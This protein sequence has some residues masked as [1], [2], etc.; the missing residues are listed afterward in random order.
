MSRTNDDAPTAKITVYGTP[1]YDTPAN[2]VPAATHWYWSAGDQWCAVC[3]EHESEW[4]ADCPDKPAIAERVISDVPR[5]GTLHF[6]L[7][8]HGPVIVA[9]ADTQIERGHGPVTCP[10]CDG[11]TFQEYGRTMYTQRVELERDEATGEILLG[12]YTGDS[13][14]VI[15]ADEAEG[16]QC[17]GCLTDIPVKG[18][19]ATAD[20]DG[21]RARGCAE[22]VA[23]TLAES[24]LAMHR[25]L[26]SENYGLDK[27]GH[28]LGPDNPDGYDVG[29][30]H[31]WQGADTMEAVAQMIDHAARDLPGYKGDTTSDETRD[32][33]RTRLWHEH[34]G[35][36]TP[37]KLN[38]LVDDI[39]RRRA[40]A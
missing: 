3:A 9:P 20:R 16:V 36:I 19:D 11:E 23:D 18:H 2:E 7:T 40:S 28:A 12:D 30:V 34:G 33:C 5:E 24:I 26:Y 1:E 38:Q 32:E 22:L 37:E 27:Y 21:A 17:R 15:E 31:E 8:P 14:S 29:Y 39:M 13:I 35:E 4:F 10:N 6:R 25:Y